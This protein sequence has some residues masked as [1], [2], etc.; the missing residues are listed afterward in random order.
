M[1]LRKLDLF[2]NLPWEASDFS[3]ALQQDMWGS[4]PAPCFEKETSKAAAIAIMETVSQ[5]QEQPL[6]WL[7]LH[8]TRVGMYDRGQTYLMWAKMQ[9]R[10]RIKEDRASGEEYEIR[11]KQEWEDV[12]GLREELSLNEEGDAFSERGVLNIGA[13]L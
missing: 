2:L 8:F 4:I 10:R 12:V 6:E 3:A 1:N 9:V 13:R 5:A 11:G 7:T